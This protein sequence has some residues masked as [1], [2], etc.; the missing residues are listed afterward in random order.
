MRGAVQASHC[1][2]RARHSPPAR[3]LARLPA[4]PSTLAPR[5]AGAP[6]VR[7]LERAPQQRR[8]ALA[9]PRRLQVGSQV[10]EELKRVAESGQARRHGARS[11]S[12]AAGGAR[13]R[14]GGEMP[15]ARGWERVEG[16]TMR[17]YAMGYPARPRAARRRHCRCLH[18]RR[19]HCRC[20]HCLRHH[21]RRRNRHSRAQP[22]AAA[23]THRWRCI[24]ASLAPVGG[25]SAGMPSSRCDHFMLS[26]P[27]CTSIVA[28]VVAMYSCCGDKMGHAGVRAGAVSG[29]RARH[30]G[31]ERHSARE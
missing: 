29:A 17:G 21:C 15:Q 16:C 31:G 2:W 10:G 22:A 24:S 1:A 7:T 26:R 3:P 30:L 19:R 13:V 23:R 12:A 8:E 28:D 11:G 4:R 6:C 27:C 14:A 5:R 18:C 20:R 25:Q 9:R